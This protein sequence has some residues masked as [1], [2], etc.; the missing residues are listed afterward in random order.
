[1]SEHRD[2]Q[3]TALRGGVA[4]AALPEGHV[5]LLLTRAGAPAP[6]VA[7]LRPAGPGQWFLVGDTPLADA[8]REALAARLLDV[9]ISDQSH[10]RVRIAVSGPQAMAMLAKGTAVDL[11]RMAVGASTAT[12]IGPLG[13]HLTRTR[14]AA[15]EL[16]VLRSFAAALWHDLRAMAAEY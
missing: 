8:G 7:G 4:L 5:L 9:A 16:M 10:G 1:M 3:R 14:E 6:D 11:E 13:V 2:I 15:F 12:L